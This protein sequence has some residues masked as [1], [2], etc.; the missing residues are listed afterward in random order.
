[1]I[2]NKVWMSFLTAAFYYYYAGLLA[3]AMRQE[4][5]IKIQ[6]PTKEIFS[7]MKI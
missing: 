1:M 5:S 3:I 2:E 7:Y 4:R 6:K